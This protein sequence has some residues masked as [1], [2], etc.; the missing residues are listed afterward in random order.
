MCGIFGYILSNT[1]EA[2]PS[3]E[4]AVQQLRHRGPDGDGTFVSEKENLVC[5]LAHTRLAIMDVSPAGRQPMSTPDGRYTVTFN[6]EIYNY[7]D[8]RAELELQGDIFDSNS[9]TEVLLLGYRRWK[10]G[11]LSRLRGMFA[12]VIWDN[13]EGSLFLARDRLGVKPLY[14]AEVPHGLLFASEVRALLGTGFV[15]KVLSRHGLVSYLA[16]GSVREPLSIVEGIVMLAAGC[17]AEYRNGVLR[18]DRYWAPPLWVDRTIAR[19]DAVLEIG[20]LLRESVAL[21][22]VSDVP[23]GIFLSGGLDSS[24]LLAL[25]TAAS[26]SRVHS[27]TVAFDEAAY[28]EGFQAERTAARFGA[29]HH[30]IRLSAKAV[31]ADQDAAVAALDQPSADGI[32]T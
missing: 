26:R 1:H 19:Q 28:D 20:S 14:I 12:F 30:A 27:F 22:L 6:G 10:R 32:N 17:S 4:H 8:L 2:R 16:F 3:L 29:D 11:V 18:T 24:A 9:D 31:L 5:G 7:R 23:V 15:P 13:V 25:A 21:R